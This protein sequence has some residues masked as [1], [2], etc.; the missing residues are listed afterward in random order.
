MAASTSTSKDCSAANN[1]GKGKRQEL[2]IPVQ[3]ET[4]NPVQQPIKSPS[5]KAFTESLALMS[6][7]RL[8]YGCTLCTDS[9]ESRSDIDKASSTDINH[10][11]NHT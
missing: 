9:S 10:N 6:L 4:I 3:E 1:N 7:D 11:K 2:R 8:L 5:R